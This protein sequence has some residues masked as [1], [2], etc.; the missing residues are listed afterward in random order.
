MWMTLFLKGAAA[1]A[2]TAPTATPPPA[3]AT[4]KK[5]FRDQNKDSEF[6]NR[7]KG[8][9]NKFKIP[10]E[11]SVEEAVLK[12]SSVRGSRSVNVL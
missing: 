2:T 1:G 9:N 7:G 4:T 10:Q 6:G 12:R 11:E 5:P 8:P 3:T